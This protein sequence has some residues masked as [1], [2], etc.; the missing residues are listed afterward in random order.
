MLS[1][2]M[3]LGMKWARSWIYLDNEEILP[4][5]QHLNLNEILSFSI[6]NQHS[7]FMISLKTV[8]LNIL[9]ILNFTSN[10]KFRV[11]KILIHSPEIFK[12]YK[13]AMLVDMYKIPCIAFRQ[14]RIKAFKM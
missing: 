5:A 14:A 10:R 12:F 13:S 8:H 7:S 11:P 4:M 3:F 2:I 1:L 9:A 6:H